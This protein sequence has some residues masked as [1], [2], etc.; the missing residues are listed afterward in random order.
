MDFLTTLI[1][2]WEVVTLLVTNVAALFV[3]PKKVKAKRKE[4]WK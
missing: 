2:N 1:V 3:D 4:K